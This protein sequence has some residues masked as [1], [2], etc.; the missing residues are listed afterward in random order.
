MTSPLQSPE[1]VV[2][3]IDA[4][5]LGDLRTLIHGIDAFYASPVHFDGRWQTHRLGQLPLGGWLLFRHRLPCT[6]L[7]QQGLR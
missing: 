2:E 4:C 7:R 6:H 5:V 1:G 3:W